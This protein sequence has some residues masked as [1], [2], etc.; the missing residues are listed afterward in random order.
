MSAL[1]DTRALALS[2]M[3]ALRAGRHREARD[4]LIEVAGA[5]RPDASVFIALAMAHRGLHDRDGALA[6]L[7]RALALEPRSL[8]ALLLK[9]DLFA[10]AGDGRAAVSFYRS[11][12]RNAAGGTTPADLAAELARAQAAVDGY[13]REY[14]A[15]LQ[16]VLRELGFDPASSSAR[17]TQS[18]DL[19]T[20]KR[21][22][23]V[24]EP[25]FYFFPGLPQVQFYERDAF[26]WAGAIE[27]AKEAI[28]DELRTLLAD[29]APF[30]PYV[31]RPAD[32]AATNDQGLAEN[33]DWSAFFL[34]KAGSLVPENAARCPR[35]VA[36][37]EGVPLYCVPGRTPNVLFSRLTPGAHIPPHTGF[38]NTRLICH[39]P[40]IVPEGC[41]FR[42]GNETRP[43]R[44]GELLVF[45]DTIEHEA[46]NR[47]ASDRVVLIF[48]VPRPEMSEEEHALVAAL[49]E[50]VDS[51]G[52]A[53]AW[54]D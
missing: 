45:D 30:T 2:A 51:F 48:D 42:V 47:G 15:H 19:M 49:F 11:A 29:G 27:A 5:G 13:A 38:I 1:P 28:R 14:E 53:P 52:D 9:A 25:R 10:E 41:A 20:G 21:R 34:W 3:A 43:W 7:D 8:R 44:E 12:L 24:Q 54:N 22:V 36:A 40:L 46:W 37:V 23:Y 17:F 18:L 26:A 31:E 16:S 35:T 33:P 6:M 50:A 4:K 32:R 39:L